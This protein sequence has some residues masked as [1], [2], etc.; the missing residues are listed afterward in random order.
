MPM[1]VDDLFNSYMRTHLKIVLCR[2]RVHAKK[3]AK[4]INTMSTFLMRMEK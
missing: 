1:R 2:W 4:K 3:M